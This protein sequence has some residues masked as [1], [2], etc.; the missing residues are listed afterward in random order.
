MWTV[1]KEDKCEKGKKIANWRMHER[2][3]GEERT[4]TK[5]TMHS[6]EHSQERILMNFSF[7]KTMV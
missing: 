6:Y 4:L 2:I 5:P 3:K 7:Q 1:Y